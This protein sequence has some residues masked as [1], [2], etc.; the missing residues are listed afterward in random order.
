MRTLILAIVLVGALGLMVGCQSGC[1]P[2]Q[3]NPCCE[4]VYVSPCCPAPSQGMGYAPAGAPAAV[5]PAP[6]GAGGACGG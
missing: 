5:A 6:M 4:P 2:C 3:P 1:D